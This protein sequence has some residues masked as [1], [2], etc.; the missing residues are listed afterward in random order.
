MSDLL[1]DNDISQHLITPV[2]KELRGLSWWLSAWG[3]VLGIVTILGVGFVFWLLFIERVTMFR[4]E[5]YVIIGG[6]TS[7][8]FAAGFLAYRQWGY[9][10]VSKDYLSSETYADLEQLFFKSSKLF[11][12]GTITVVVISSTI[13]PIMGAE[14]YRNYSYSYYEE[15]AIEYPMEE[16]PVEE[17]WD[18]PEWEE[19]EPVNLDEAE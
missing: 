6:L 5:Q 14:V 8:V 10:T 7:T 3:I 4:W 9:A 1:D 19:S 13:L 11:Q 18:E 15:E 12:M 17:A 16:M 2:K